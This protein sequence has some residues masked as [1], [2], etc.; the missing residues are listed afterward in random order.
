MT[1]VTVVTGATRNLGL[2]L[3]QGL[4]ERLADG[5]VVYLTGRDHNRVAEA[6]ETI[7]AVGAEVRGEVLDVSDADAVGRFAAS[8]ADRHGGVDIV[9]SNHYARVEP[10]DDPAQVIDHYVAVNNLGTTSVLRAFAPLLRDGGRLLVVASRAG[11]L[12]ALAPVLHDHFDD[13]TSLD[14]VDR[15]VCTWRDAVRERRAA[16]Q[17]WPAWI[18]I[19]SKIGQVAAVRTLA[20]QRHT[21]DLRRGILIAAL[22]PGLIDTGASRPWLDMSGARTPA[23]AARWP[24]DLALDPNPDPGLYGELVLSGRVLSWRP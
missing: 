6:V 11:T 24:L 8:L 23:Q 4:A 5:D 22:C 10:D 18:N 7:P 19:P 2:A 15:A 1:V 17:A 12:R 13:L 14:D 3:A 9:F 21:T 16:G 20:R